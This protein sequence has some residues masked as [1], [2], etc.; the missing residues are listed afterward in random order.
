MRFLHQS[1]F[2]HHGCLTSHC[3]MITG[4]WELKIAN[5]GL[6]GI[7]NIQR[8]DDFVLVK[9]H[10]EQAHVLNSLDDLLWLAPESV[11]ATTENVYL[12]FPSQQADVY[13]AGI[14]INEILTRE[15]PYSELHQSPQI[16]F[17]QVCEKNIRPEVKISATDQGDF[18]NGMVS[19]VQDCL[20]TD[21]L[22]R[23]TFGALGVSVL[24]LF[25]SFTSYLLHSN[26]VTR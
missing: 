3:C 21:P 20:Q 13:S 5:Y 16:I 11:V 4:R 2:Q 25:A 6:E 1:K 24:R 9:S 23:P 26:L 8:V 14:I 18:T 17:N 22:L 12:T 7:K 10:N 19:I 15:K